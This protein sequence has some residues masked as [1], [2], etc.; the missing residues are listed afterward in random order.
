MTEPSSRASAIAIAV[1]DTTGGVGPGKEQTTS[2]GSR[3]ADDGAR[4]AGDRGRNGTSTQSRSCGGSEVI[5][6]A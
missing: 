4:S 3:G 6:P 5:R 1:V 2:S